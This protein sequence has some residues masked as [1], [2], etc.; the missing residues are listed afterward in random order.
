[1]RRARSPR[2]CRVRGPSSREAGDPA[3]TNDE[4]PQY[5][6]ERRMTRILGG[7]PAV[8]SG[9]AEAERAFLDEHMPTY[10]GGLPT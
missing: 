1:M 3:G 6:P 8:V 10:G 9:P 4:W 7:L 2:R 5:E